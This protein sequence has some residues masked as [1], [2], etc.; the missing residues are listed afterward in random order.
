MGGNF[1]E[2][3]DCRLTAP[4]GHQIGMGEDET[5][6]KRLLLAG[7]R[8]RRWH[9]LRAMKDDEILPMRAFGRAPGSRI[10]LAIG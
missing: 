1:V 5:K 7:R 8:A 9:P 10:A 4:V 2:Q 6:E 3:K